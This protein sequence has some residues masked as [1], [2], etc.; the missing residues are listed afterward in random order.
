[1]CAPY[2]GSV[3]RRSVLI[4]LVAPRHG[5][6]GV[7]AV[8]GTVLARSSAQLDP[9]RSRAALDAR[10]DDRDHPDARR[11]IR[12]RDVTRPTEA[13]AG[14]GLASARSTPSGSYSPVSSTAPTVRPSFF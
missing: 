6:I 10:Q 13:A 4:G 5:R 12:T 14:D 11:D 2:P 3:S 8:G 7:R 1:M 9:E